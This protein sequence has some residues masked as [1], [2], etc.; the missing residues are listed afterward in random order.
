MSRDSSVTEPIKQ[1]AWGQEERDLLIRLETKFDYMA[2]DIKLLKDGTNQK[3]A[4]AEIRVTQLEKLRD[5]FN[6]SELAAE[7]KK[8]S[9]YIH[10]QRLTKRVLIATISGVGTI[11]GVLTSVIVH[12]FIKY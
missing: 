6:I 3:L 2:E 8:S 9:I 7:V 4:Q 1:S 12:Y 10:D 5:E 11:I